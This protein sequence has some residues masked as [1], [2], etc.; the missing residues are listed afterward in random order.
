MNEYLSALYIRLK[1]V[2]VFRNILSDGV[3]NALL[4]LLDF[5][6][7]NNDKISA[8]DNYGNFVHE[9]YNNT[10]NLSE[11]IFGAVSDD[12]NVFVKK[13]SHGEAVSEE[14]TDSYE[15]SN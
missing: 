3:I 7:N 10:D 4:S 1:A 11:Y 6:I 5:C 8:A 13:K 14:M 12:E 9:L 15:R 2:A